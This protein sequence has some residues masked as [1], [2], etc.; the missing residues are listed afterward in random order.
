M[1][2][3]IYNDLCY[4]KPKG[5]PWTL[6]TAGAPKKKEIPRV[7]IYAAV[8]KTSVIIYHSLLSSE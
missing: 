6:R 3:I 8:K 1:I 5:T 7:L 4:Y 2:T